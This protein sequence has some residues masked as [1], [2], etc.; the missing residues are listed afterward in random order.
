VANWDLSPHSARKVRVKD[1]M[2]TRETAETTDVDLRL[3]PPVSTSAT[4]EV[5]RSY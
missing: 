1:W 2:R 3:A 5:S 4:A